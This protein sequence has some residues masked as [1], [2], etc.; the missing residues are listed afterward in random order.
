ML[1]RRI[2]QVAPLGS[3]ISVTLQSG[4]QLDGIL[5]SIDLE[6]VILE[7]RPGCPALA[8][9]AQVA[10]FEVLELDPDRVKAEEVVT[11]VRQSD[12]PPAPAENG[13]GAIHV[14]TLVSLGPLPSHPTVPAADSPYISQAA[15][16]AD[17]AARPVLAPLTEV[18]LP[19]QADA[20]Q[21]SAVEPP[22]IE[23][24]SALY[25]IEA[26]L[27][28]RM[29]TARLE[30]EPPSFEFPD[31]DVPSHGSGTAR[32]LLERVSSRYANARKIGELDPKFGRIQSII[33]DLRQLSSQYP[34]SIV[35]K[36]HLAVCLALA[37]ISAEAM[38]V[39][40]E[41]ARLDDA[42]AE[43]WLNL[44]A[45]AQR[46]NSEE[47]ACLALEQ[48]F[49]Q[50]PARA[51][52]SAWYVFLRLVYKFGN[53]V[54]LASLFDATQEPPPAEAD[55]LLTHAG[56]FLLKATRGEAAAADALQACRR[57]AGSRAVVCEALAQLPTEGTPNY[58]KVVEDWVWESRSAEPRQERP[59]PT[60]TIP[61]R[62]AEPLGSTPVQS[63]VQGQIVHYIPDKTYG[64]IDDGSSHSKRWGSHFFHRSSVVDDRLLQQLEDGTWTGLPVVFQSV[65]GPRGK[66]ALQ[67]SKERTPGEALDLA[68]DYA[69]QGEYSQAIAQVRRLLDRSDFPEARVLHER[70][71]EFARLTAVPKGSNPYARARRLQ[72]IEKEYD[73][74]V[75]LFR[76]AIQIGDNAE[77]AVKDLAALLMQ[78]DRAA[79]A[80]ELLEKHQF[81]VSD[82]QSLQNHLLH[83]YQKAG[84]WAKA[85]ALLKGKLK[86]TRTN[87]RD[88]IM[89]L[90]QVARAAIQQ[91]N[92]PEAEKYLSEAKELQPDNPSVGR[93]L[94]L[95]L[96]RQR[97]YDEAVQLLQQFDPGDSRTSELLAA[98]AR[99]RQSGVL[100]PM[101]DAGLLVEAQLSD[102]SSELSRFTRFFLDR[103]AFKGVRTDRLNENGYCGTGEDVE[104]DTRQLEE[105]ARKLG[106]SRPRDRS[107]YYLSAARIQFDL[108][109]GDYTLVYRYL[110]R[111]F[112]SCGDAAVGENRHL[113][114]AREWYI[115]ALRAHDGDRAESWRGEEQ[116][117]VNALVRC[118][119]STLGQGAIPLSKTPGIDAAIEE[120][121]NRH[122]QRDKV[123]ELIRYLSTHSKYAGERIL[124][125]LF[126]SRSLQT[127]ACEYLRSK[128]VL[129]TS[130]TKPSMEQFVKWW[131]ELRQHAN[132]EHNRLCAELRSLKGC[133][134][135]GAWLGNGIEQ[136]KGVTD[137][138]MFDLDRQ[139]VLE[140]KDVLD[141]AME[142]CKQNRFEE[143][144]RL[145]NQTDLRCQDLLR[146]IEEQPTKISVEELYTVV[147]GVRE[148]VADRLRELYDTARPSP[149]LRLAV[150]S[151]CP[152]EDGRI[153]VQIVIEN[154]MGRG[155]AE[156][157]E[158]VLDEAMDSQGGGDALFAADKTGLPIDGSLRGGDQRIV[159][160]PLRLSDRVLRQQDFSIPLHA[161]FRTRSGEIE[162]TPMTIFAIRLNPEGEFEEID[163]PFANYAEGNIVDN[164]EMFMGR[165]ELIEAIAR[166]IRAPRKGVV[167][168]GQK[169][170]GKS[171]IL[172]HLKNRL[173]E[174]REVIVLDVG[175]IASLYTDESELSLF[176]SLL[177]T[178]LRALGQEIREP[179]GLAPLPGLRIPAYAEFV[180][181]QNRLMLFSE[182]FRDFARARD[183]TP[184]WRGVRC[185]L[186]IDEFSYVYHWILQG[187]LPETF[188][189]NWKAL[190]QEDFF[191]A[192]LV[193]QDNM[194]KFKEHFANEFGIFQDE[195]ISY[196]KRDD[197]IRLIQ[198]PVLIVGPDG[199]P[200]TRY[201]ER[202]IERLLELTAGSPFYIQMICN[203]LVEYMNRKR[204]RR[205][206][207][208][209]VEQ[210][211][212]ELIRGVN[213]LSKDK[214]ENLYNSGDTSADA[215]SDEDTLRVCTVVA[216]NSRT[217]PCN[218]QS[219]T[220]QTRHSL[221]DILAD[222]VRRD[223]LER[224]RGHYY[225]IRLGLFKEWLLA[226]QGG[227]TP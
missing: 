84:H 178:M 149:E 51:H 151:Y 32:Q 53:Y 33:N 202:A 122:P 64:F 168:F 216:L 50:R 181:H 165:E 16:I 180:E 6:S 65:E 130:P 105:I 103:C 111:S 174:R 21:A 227:K 198:Q 116:D 102:F 221:D 136:L 219:I 70:W 171:S 43:D 137:R 131:N 113:D 58:R 205:V 92:F 189:K 8:A 156:S 67:I 15:A 214:F 77:S 9:L 146:Q 147:E 141:Q 108:G 73:R 175:N 26:H 2:Q 59:S 211:K 182:T 89:L 217:G 212:E 45:L 86:A 160:L 79:E 5:T 78:V 188:M 166:V 98:I 132:S 88:R 225:Q 190:L 194:P 76:K 177:W 80:V 101:D 114:S 71:R 213:A 85:E 42:K 192:V 90:R 112:A 206:T 14:R 62:R 134:L 167:V 110:C 207:E 63:Q 83:A 226:H 40:T 27:E 56:V 93:D 20:T 99:A 145:C 48:V 196:L 173:R 91:E 69:D 222:L 119:Y 28:A 44:A 22:A 154:K 152:G 191:N 118:L 164:P 95:C 135:T 10:A 41:A 187:K 100:L 157:V 36:R 129:L 179:V 185:V 81:R 75:E 126:N 170:A 142:L 49:R 11:Q 215:I 61:D 23:L 124:P 184:E 24:L 60:T 162:T 161:K 150:E 210:V 57:T 193:G 19:I 34:K 25:K 121:I 223:V 47:L 97:R 203:R 107:N 204:A 46:Q 143:V 30:P 82:R 176:D 144:E 3:R 169:R 133:Q 186:L 195:R 37:N 7:T 139:R 199:Q 72:L 55:D 125:R 208:A 224:E 123:F 18:A 39:A 128:G 155:P 106:T 54:P 117:V 35:L 1:A 17:A 115:E 159:Y 127:V 31:K 197:A 29:A 4:K 140:L 68:R 109:E 94:A 163:N 12:T 13:E 220:C 172:Y 38:A 209:D 104:H 148:K 66:V 218:R 158:V 120:V 200:D 52:E 201:R 87:P 138:L 96:S 74:A 183:R 153:E